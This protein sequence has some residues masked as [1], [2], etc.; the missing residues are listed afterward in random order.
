MRM[1]PAGQSFIVWEALQMLQDVV[2]AAGCGL[3]QCLRHMKLKKVI[4]ALKIE[5][6]SAGVGAG[7]KVDVEL[8]V[9]LKETPT[10]IE[11]EVLDGNSMS[12]VK[13]ASVHHLN[14]G[15]QAGNDGGGASASAA[16]NSTRVRSSRAKLPK[17]R[18]LRQSPFRPI[19][20]AT[21]VTPEIGG[22]FDDEHPLNIPTVMRR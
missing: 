19:E 10:G 4:D 1:L 12:S 2:I 22:R 17:N 8:A 15:L 3:V 11:C 21:E 7:V 5:L 16:K 6:R 18:A 13:E 20:E 14:L 9:L